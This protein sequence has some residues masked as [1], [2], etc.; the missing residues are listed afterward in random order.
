[1]AWEARLIP[2]L[3]FR[4]RRFLAILV[5]ALASAFFLLSHLTIQNRLG[6]VAFYSGGTLLACII[7]LM[8]FGL[9]KRLV[10]LPILSVAAWTQIHIYTGIF[11]F[12]VYLAHVP[13][14]IANGFFE[15]ALSLLF[16]VVSISGFYG[17][18]I[19]RT[20]PRKMTAV[21]GEF[22]FDQFSWHRQTL[23]DRAIDVLR[24][25]ENSLASPVL[26]N[27]FRD[28]LQPYFSTGVTIDFLL[29]PNGMRRRRLLLGL[30]DL[31][32]YLTPEVRSASGQLASL[33]R[34]RDELDYHFALQWKLR[35]WLAVH[36]TFASVL[37]VA[38]L[39]HVLLVLN[40]L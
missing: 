21:P 28:Y 14:I 27:Y 1:M 3:T 33:V 30:Q 6:H 24:N 19:S 25:L 12:V 38:S 13:S 10:M 26:A 40:F 7:L 32:R 37:L 29:M 36:A 35:V 15:S 39:L 11:A 23:N 22:R 2:N 4:Q 9:R 34:K 8:L 5:T 16:L 20:A 18:Y 31:D 17:V